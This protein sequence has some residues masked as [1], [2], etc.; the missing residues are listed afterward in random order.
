MKILTILIYVEHG[1]KAMGL[2]LWQQLWVNTLA[3]Q[4]M[5]RGKEHNLKQ[6]LLFNVTLRY[7]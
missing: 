5:K 2:T 3:H 7:F 6:A 4:L 1:A